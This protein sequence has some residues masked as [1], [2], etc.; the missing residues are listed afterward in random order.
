MKT[1]PPEGVEVSRSLDQLHLVF[2]RRREVTVIPQM[3]SEGWPWLKKL[4]LLNIVPLLGAWYALAVLFF[5]KISGPPAMNLLVLLMV[6]AMTVVMALSHFK[7]TPED[8]MPQKKMTILP[9]AEVTLTPHLLRIKSGGKT[10]EFFTETIEKVTNDRAGARIR[11]GG[12]IHYLLPD[13][14]SEERA[15]LAEVLS[16]RVWRAPSVDSQAE[17]AQLEALLKQR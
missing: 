17:R 6:A 1:P 11:S 8:S 13:R 2:P 5:W 12:R 15:W 10:I 7:G 9:Y 16:E 3:Y 4:P 14:S